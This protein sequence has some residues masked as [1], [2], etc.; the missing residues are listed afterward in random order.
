MTDNIKTSPE[1]QDY[2]NKIDIEVKKAY[3]IAGKARKKGYD[4]DDEVSIPLAKNMA[5]RVE[6]LVSTVAPQIINSGISERIIE[7]EKKYGS[8]EWRVALT[9]AL[10]IAQEKFCKFEN[11]K[12]AIEIGI[13]VGFAY[14][15]MGTVASPLEGFVGIEIRTRKQDN[16]EYFA[17]KYSGP[18]RSAGGTGGSVSVIIA[19]YLRKKMGYSTYDPTENEINRMIRETFD[20]HERA[21]NLQYLPS[22]KELGFML[23]N[24]PVQIDG[25]PTES[26]EVS[27]FKDLERIP[28]NRIRGGFCLVVAE[29]L[30]QKAAKLW[31]RLSKWGHDFQLEHWDF[32]EEFL[33]IQKKMKARGK[34]NKENEKI[35]PNYTFI[36]DLVA[37]RPILAFPM[38][39]GGFRLRYGRSRTSGYS[40]SNINP[41]TMVVLNGYIATGT[42]LKIERPGKAT[43]VNP[44]NSIEGPTVKLKDGSV[45]RID[46]EKEAKKYV[47]EIKEIIF[48]GDILFNYGDFFNRGHI[49][50][51]AGYCEEWWVQE[52]EKAVVDTFGNLDI[53]KLSNLLDMD[54]EKINSIIKN[55]FYIKPDA[56]LSIKISEE[57]KIPLHPNYTFYWKTISFDEF[58]VFLDWLDDMKINREEKLKI[59]LPLKK[60]PKTIL[61]NLGVQHK[62]ATNEFVVIE[63]N[64]AAA[65]LSNLNINEKQDIEKTKKTAQENKDKNVLDI[66][67]LISSIKVMDK[68]G[69]FIGARMGRPEKAKMRK[70][71]GS[72]HVLFPVGEE[73]DRLRCFQAAIENGKITAELPLY[74]C[75]KCNNKTIFSVCEKCGSKTKKM[76]YCNICGDIEKEKCEHGE[77]KPYKI[78]SVDINY[79]FDYSM[80]KLKIK[81]CPDL[82]KGVRGTSN[83][84]HIPEHLIKGILRAEHDIYVNKDGTTRYDMT[85]LPV[86]HFKP[87]EIR[88]SIE[89]LKELGYTKDIYGKEIIDENQVIE[90]KPQDV[91]LPSCPNSSE[92]GADIVLFNVANFIDDVLS[93][94]YELKPYYKM[95]SPDELAGELVVALAPHTSAGTVCRIL[96]FSKTQG[97]YAHP[98]IHAATR[99]DCDGDEASV[100][101]LMDALLNFSRQ[102]LPAHRGST[103][104][105]CLV[106]TSKVIPAE[107]DDMFFDLD[108]AW[109]YPLE[110]YNASIDYKSPYE[111]E[112]E[113]ISDRLGKPTEYEKMGF[114]HPVENINSGIL[115]SSYK[116]IPSMEDKLKGQMD[117]AEKIRAVNQTEVASMVIDKHFIKDIKGNLRKFSMQQ[118]RCVKCNKKFRRPPLMGKCDKCGGKII[119]TISEG[120]IIKYLKPSISLANKYDVPVYLKQ[121]LELTQR[122]VD[123]VFGKEKEKQEGLGKWFG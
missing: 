119:F 91:I 16:K 17:I 75:P 14:I 69:I 30:S 13:R 85:Q 95:K 93:K 80:K 106:I 92:L 2:I 101:L 66:I 111:V 37:G 94:L 89:K 103:Q 18:I 46:S 8:Q 32:L 97:F 39:T 1:I 79:Y 115:C 52:L 61:E 99:R 64:D 45:M 55:Y 33:E 57:L 87:K 109:K 51:P 62:V 120:S 50:A 40:S 44:C 29:C 4:P 21:T 56:N 86:T 28:T 88:T 84:D 58:T 59:I 67:N 42:Q 31:N 36:Q 78:Q 27:N 60:E 96:G 24:L 70:L 122:R 54:E 25:D 49:L 98:M 118:F 72:P 83:K 11:K 15:T 5:E 63:G 20:Y 41:A 117:L 110:F 123:D 35:S 26:I 38:R 105:A 48:L 3:E 121:T 19:D 53:T 12:E 47:D 116:E 82:I 107:V 43:T 71:T 68:A 23:R 100:M 77:A 76:Y 73:G 104:D 102:F 74:K 10:E 113:Q 65:L 90:I 112:I 6:G 7:L 34:V 22:E 108:V 114:T 9:I 81:T